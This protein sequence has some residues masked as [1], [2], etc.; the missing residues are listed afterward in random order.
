MGLV[1]EFWVNL[2][3]L[4]FYKYYFSFVFLRSLKKL[5][6]TYQTIYKFKIST[7]QKRKYIEIYEA[8]QIWVLEFPMPAANYKHI[9]KKAMK[10]VV[11][12]ERYK[13]AEEFFQLFWD[14]YDKYNNVQIEG[15][16]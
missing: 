14:N 12:E 8:L 1:H 5:P 6:A 10:I 4:N 9:R 2:K 3:E 7:W 16:D 13:G 11:E 15:N